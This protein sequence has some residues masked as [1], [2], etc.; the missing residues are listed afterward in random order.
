MNHVV[1]IN[2]QSYYKCG[3]LVPTFYLTFLKI[4]TFYLCF[5]PS[6]FNLLSNLTLLFEYFQFLSESFIFYCMIFTQA[7]KKKKKNL[8]KAPCPV[9]SYQFK[10]VWF[11]GCGPP[12]VY[13]IF[14]G[15]NWLH[16][17]LFLYSNILFLIFVNRKL[18]LTNFQECFVL[19]KSSEF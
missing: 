15:G 5:F 10:F 1:I 11:V 16:T 18:N 12:L 3:A 6:Y 7:K 14:T 13:I 8:N 2:C 4:L 19:R 9:L 17:F